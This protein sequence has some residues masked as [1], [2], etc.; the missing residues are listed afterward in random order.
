MLENVADPVVRFCTTYGSFD[1]ELF[2]GAA[3]N[4]V[5]N[6]EHYVNANRYSGSFVHRLAP[7]FV[8]QMGGWDFSDAGG[9]VPIPQD[10]AIALEAH[11]SNVART[12]AMAHSQDPN[13]ATSQFYINLVNNP[14]LDSAPGWAVFGK[15]IQGWDVVL[16]IAAR[17]SLNLQTDPAFAGPFAPAFGEVPVTAAYSAATGVHASSLIYI[18]TTPCPPCPADVD[19]G[20]GQGIR[21]GG[22]TID[23]LLFFLQLFDAGDPRSQVEHYCTSPDPGP[24]SLENLLYY[25][26]RYAEGC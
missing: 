1:I 19:N 17:P 7:N 25:L 6:F 8:V 23:D 14:F 21:D 15:V 13:D 3:P 24:P 18:G 12:V 26:I 11:R 20:S 9:L 4:T 2:P 10:P 5:A 22:V 16:R